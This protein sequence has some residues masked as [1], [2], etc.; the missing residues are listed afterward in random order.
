ME[1]RSLKRFALLISVSLLASWLFASTDVRADNAPLNLSISIERAAGVSYASFAPS[2]A[3]GSISV[4]SVGLGGPAVNPLGLPRAGAD[5]ILPMGLTLGGAVGYG[6]VSLSANPNS[7]SSTSVS[8][9]AW[10]L[11]PRVGYV[12]HLAPFFDLWPRAGVTFGEAEGSI[13]SSLFTSANC[14]GSTASGGGCTTTTTT[15]ASQGASIF[16]VS[17]SPEVV[18][19]LRLTGSLNVLGGVSLDYVFATSASAGPS[20]SSQTSTRGVPTTES[21]AGLGLADTCSS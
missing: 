21:R 11:A 20:G 15:T 13:P 7:G 17:I 18:A 3:G 10:L 14:S 2:G 16:A 6:N 5:A 1:P 8:G 9:D 12:L 19:V 4:T